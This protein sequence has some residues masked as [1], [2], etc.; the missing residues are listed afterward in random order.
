MHHCMAMALAIVDLGSEAKVHSK[1]CQ[2]RIGRTCQLA[3][4]ADSATCKVSEQPVL[5]VTTWEAA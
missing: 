5:K 1:Q 3:M 2:W 4:V